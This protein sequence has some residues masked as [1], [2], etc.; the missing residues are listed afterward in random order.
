[1]TLSPSRLLPLAA[2]LSLC[3]F[4]LSAQA[5][6]DNCK[7]P[8]TKYAEVS[9]TAD[10]KYFVGY[11]A[12]Y[13]V[14]TLLD[15]QGKALLNVKGYD[16]VDYYGIENGVFAVMKN[17]KVGY[18][19]TQGKLVVPVVYDNMRDPDD[20]Y[21]ET[22]AESPSQ[23]RIIVAKGGKLGIIDTSN[24]VIMPFS[25][26]YRS[27]ESFSEG[28]APVISKSGKWGFIDKDGKEI[29]APQYD[30]TNGHFGGVYGFSEGLAGMEKG[31]KWGYITKTG[32][33]AIPFVY[34]EIR[35][36]KEGFAGVL[37][38]N[39]WGFIDGTNKTIIPFKYADS[40]VERYSSNFMAANYF[41]FWDGIAE[42]ATIN[43]QTVCINKSD[44]KVACPQ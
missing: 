6:V 35:P 26:K 38:G 34:D 33:V 37:K 12:D 2:A 40:N 10:D 4:T 21:D 9:C 5:Y 1:M 20:K 17:S 14:Q 19:N 36:F 27:I 24:K 32:K 31:G 23:G 29:I 43:Q 39:K 30:G 41:I 25:N 7:P 22:W 28:T 15:K 16:D 13:S 8:K 18:M 11:N 3:S 44:K 42:V